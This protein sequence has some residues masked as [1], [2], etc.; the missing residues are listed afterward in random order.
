LL[1]LKLAAI[2]HLYAAGIRTVLVPTLARGIN[3]DQI[4]AITQFAV[5]RT[6]RIAASIPSAATTA[7]LATA[8]AWR[9]N[10]PYRSS[11][12]GPPNRDR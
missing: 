2:E 12:I 1:N 4:G 8:T 11:S 6:N 10:S 9:G 3:D 5:E 7:V